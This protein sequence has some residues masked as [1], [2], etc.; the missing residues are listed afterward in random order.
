MPHPTLQCAHVDTVT[1]LSRA[2]SPLAA[3]VAFCRGTPLRT[4]IESRDAT[5]LE[6]A[7]AASAAALSQRFGPGP[8]EGRMQAHVITSGR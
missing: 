2:A 1:K 8:I 7:T 6:E 4:E 5:R 3:A